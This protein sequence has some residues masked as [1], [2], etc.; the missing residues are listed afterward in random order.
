MSRQQTP[1]NLLSREKGGR[2]SMLPGCHS[3]SSPDTGS[4]GE[5][6]TEEGKRMVDNADSGFFNTGKKHGFVSSIE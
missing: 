6:E 2:D 4:S 5:T 1:H 3:A